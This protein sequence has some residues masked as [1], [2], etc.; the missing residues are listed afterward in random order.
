MVLFEDSEF[1]CG[2]GCGRGINYMSSDLLR[3]LYP[4][5]TK[6]DVPFP[7]NSAFRC[8]R[9]N[10]AIG[11]VKDSAH[12]LG[13]AVDIRCDNS[14]D[15]FKILRGLILAGF[16]RI[17]IYDWGLHADCDPSKPQGVI[18]II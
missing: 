3:L 4:A 15:R 1:E 12:C 10:D 2:C 7:I 16:K 8:Q 13:Y 17:G 9:H 5:R 6:A 11:G 18:W 14:G